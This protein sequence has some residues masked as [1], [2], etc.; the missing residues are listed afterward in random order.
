MNAHERHRPTT[1]YV[2][3]GGGARG[4]YEAGVLLYLEEE[5]QREA[6]RPLRPDIVCGTSIGALHACQLAAM[7]HHPSPAGLLAKHWRSLRTED[8]LSF[9]WWDVVRLVREAMG[10]AKHPP[11]TPGGREGGLS[12]PQLLVAQILHEAPWPCI[13][14]NIRAG[15]IQALAVTATHVATGKPTVFIQRSDGPIP[16]F[17]PNY[18]SVRARIGP[19]HALASAAIP[20]IFPPVRIGT[21]LYLDGGLKLNVPLSPALRLG[22]DRILVISLRSADI[23]EPAGEHTTEPSPRPNALFLLGKALSALLLESTS[24][25]LDRLR[26][27]NA[28]LDAGVRA[29]GPKFVQQ[30]NANLEPKAGPLRYIRALHLRPSRDLGAMAVDYLRS[31]EF[32]ERA[33]GRSGRILRDLAERDPASAADAASYLLFDAGYADLL[34]NLGREDARRRRDDLLRFFSD[35]PESSAEGLTAVAGAA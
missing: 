25:D 18:I 33:L 12:D 1:A 10:R 8:V 35:E 31:P 24:Q 19:R 34:L 13:G 28:I 11:R 6:G 17:D 32:R 22:A 15:R 29:Y 21:E 20:I 27:I 3:G 23:D 2:L 5:L 4:A 16:Q 7:A 9:R 26:K 14:R 30:I